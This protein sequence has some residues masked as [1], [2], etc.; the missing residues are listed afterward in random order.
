MRK[1]RKIARVRVRTILDYKNN[2]VGFRWYATINMKTR[3][4]ARCGNEVLSL[5]THNFFLEVGW[6]AT[7]N[8]SNE[9]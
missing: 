2:S 8:N 7:I 3:S 1:V 4:K 9:N 5:T 6:Y